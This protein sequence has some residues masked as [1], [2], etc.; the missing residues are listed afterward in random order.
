MAKKIA[1]AIH[2]GGVGKTTSAK[3]I[4]AALAGAGKRTLLIDLDEQANATKGLGVDPDALSAT[5][6]DL[7]TD[8]TI[9]PSMAVVTT[10]VDGLHLIAGH[11]NLS[12]TET[13]MAFQRSDPTAP[14]P[15]VAL[16]TLLEALEDHYDFIILDTPP[17][18]GFMTINALA[19]ADELVIPAA[20]SAYTQDGLARTIEAYERAVKTY[21]PGLRLRGILITRVK[22]TNASSAVLDGIGE[23]YSDRVIPQLIVES[24]AVDEAEQL[25]QPVVLYDPES[26]AAQG[27]KRVAEILINE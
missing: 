10:L 27:Y 19:A 9:E 24:T 14:D 23:A 11:P 21:N 16:K 20:A 5:L 8:P 18:L 7:F 15:I 13:G 12:K 26:A 2:K 3:N 1:I 25:N 6:N 22:R 17:S 4:A